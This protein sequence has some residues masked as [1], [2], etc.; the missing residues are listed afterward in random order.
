MKIISAS[1]DLTKIDK[2]LIKEH[3]N[4]SK[5]YQISIIL[6]DEKDQYGND[7]SIS[8]GQTKE[9]REAREKKTFIGNGKVVWEGE[10]RSNSSTSQTQSGSIDNDLPF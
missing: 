8:N 7:V 9:Q 6:N 5:Y 3:S 2:S 4:G 10:N 1:I